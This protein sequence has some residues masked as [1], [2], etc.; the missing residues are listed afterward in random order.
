LAEKIHSVSVQMCTQS[1]G[2][3]GMEVQMWSVDEYTKYTVLTQF[4]VVFSILATGC[5]FCV[6]M[7]SFCVHSCV[8]M[9]WLIC[10]HKDRVHIVHKVHVFFSHA[11]VCVARITP[12]G[13]VYIR[14]WNEFT[15][16]PYPLFPVPPKTTFSHSPMRG[17]GRMISSH[18]P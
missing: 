15:Q 7:N 9:N 12:K 13:F 17:N 1:L 6:Y 18:P 4:W 11:W 14:P 2:F 8:Q 5:W 16:V 3:L 10:A